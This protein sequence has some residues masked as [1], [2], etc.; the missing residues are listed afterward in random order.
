MTS[1]VSVDVVD[2]RGIVGL[3]S[4]L[5]TAL[6]HHCVSIADTE[7]CND[8]YVSAAVVSLDSCG[9][10]CSAAADDEN[11]NIVLGVLKVDL[12]GID[13]AVS[14]EKSSQLVGNL[15][16]LVGADLRDPRTE[17]RCSRGGRS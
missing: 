9:R 17:T 14:L 6:S 7:L 8:H 3:I 16:A 15:L 12:G 13:T 1:A 10:T 11:V 4:S 5:D 2:S